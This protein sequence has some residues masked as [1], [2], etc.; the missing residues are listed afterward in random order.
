MPQTK[1]RLDTLPFVMS[2]TLPC[3]SPVV[4]APSGVPGL[5]QV[6]HGGFPANRLYLVQGVPG[7]GKTTL[8]MQFL[9]EGGRRGEP[10]LYISLS[11]TREEIEVVAGSH[12][13]DLSGISLFEMT[14]AE[15]KLR[16][17]TETSFFHPSE[18]ELS[19]TT[20]TLL[21]EVERLRPTRVVF[22]SLSELRLL[23]DSPLRYRR[24]VLR[25]KQ[26]FSDKKTTVLLLD[27]F[28][29]NDSDDQVHSIAHGVL[30]LQRS[31]P[32]YGSARRKLT[33]EKL[34]GSKFSEG[35]HDFALRKGG[36]KV[37][38][39]LV[40]EDHE[41]DLV[42]ERVTTGSTSLDALLGGGLDRGTSTMFLGPPGTGKS[43]LA[44]GLAIAAAERGEKS[45]LLLFDE[46]P[47]TLHDR[48]RQLKMNLSAHC[49]SGLIT[50]RSIDPAA[51]SPGEV[52]ESIMRAVI[53]DGV[54]VITIDSINGYVNSMPE[55]RLL[56]LQLHE[57]LSFLARKSVL[58]I[59]VLSQQG[60]MG[61]M[62]N[63][64]DL[65][66]LADTVILS[67]F[68]EAR[69]AMKL[70]LAVVKKRSGDHE[71]TIRDY[72]FGQGGLEMGEPLT[73]MQGV[74][75]GVPTFLPG[76][77]ADLFVANQAKK[78]KDAAP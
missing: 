15:E 57:L 46:S 1:S 48:T 10:V 77:Q 42:T 33:V 44:V 9:M 61:Q 49:A 26:Y 55:A 59:L 31:I 78:N 66:Y 54:R 4:R 27:D 37:F 76:P 34:R 50:V 3:S 24:Q 20:E 67:R 29:G 73:Q 56:N 53:E 43:T 40:S 23:A 30:T 63:Q 62:Q 13:W 51:V 14:A 32:D 35:Q 75:T 69:G 17:E 65:S 16:A 18:V 19:R 7:T 64:V 25:L 60:M 68:F 72:W 70:A 28:S 71:R 58:T 11:E 2:S 5:D 45:L 12:G 38:A 22:D 47:L 41:A 74:L 8:A 52:T 21:A 36:M 39:R 6:L